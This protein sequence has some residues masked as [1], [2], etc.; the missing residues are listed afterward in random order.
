[1]SSDP[2][3]DLELLQSHSMNK[4]ISDQ[5]KEFRRFMQQRRSALSKKEREAKSRFIA[6][7]LF[8]QELY[9]SADNIVIY[10]PFGSEINTL[11]I[12]DDALKNGKKIILPK[13]RNNELQ[14]C[15]VKD[16]KIDLV[17]GAFG[18]MEPK[19]TCKVAR[20]ED[21]DL[22]VL[23]GTCFDRK[24]NRIGY[25]GGFFDRILARMPAATSKIALA[26]DIQVLDFIPNE[27]FDKKVDLIITE[28]KIYY[29]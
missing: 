16:L 8:D 19:A 22:I 12:I 2:I 17:E 10:Y 20:L 1:V 4:S 21:I 13:V 6:N 23:P 9:K 28:T 29:P 11:Y 3:L 27:E 26:F 15:Y 25:G 14:L 24:M 5:K 7:A 18:I